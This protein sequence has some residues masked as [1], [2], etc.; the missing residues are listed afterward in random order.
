[1]IQKVLYT[2]QSV[3][4]PGRPP[5]HTPTSEKKKKKKLAKPP[6]SWGAYG[7]D[8]ILHHTSRHQRPS[9]PSVQ[10]RYYE[11]SW[12]PVRPAPSPARP[13]TAWRWP[14]RSPHCRCSLPTA[15]HDRL[16][17]TWQTLVSLVKKKKGFADLE[18]CMQGFDSPN[19]AGRSCCRRSHSCQ[20][21]PD[22]S[23]W[24][25]CTWPRPSWWRAQTLPPDWLRTERDS[26]TASHNIDKSLS[27]FKC[28]Q[29]N[30]TYYT[31]TGFN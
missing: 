1:M 12:R 22:C 3:G 16:A 17:M 8:R 11:D 13:R 23:S 27:K 10:L 9:S 19:L 25:T 5:T 21:L 29:K 18:V 26:V 2:V 6:P 7:S 31:L 30:I 20:S 15:S 4:G 24:S 28:M 14:R